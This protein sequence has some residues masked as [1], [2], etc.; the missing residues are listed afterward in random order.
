MNMNQINNLTGGKPK[1]INLKEIW[2]II[3]KRLWIVIVISILT[4]I[5]GYIYTTYFSSDPQYQTSRRIIIGADSNN[6]GTLQ[7]MI[8][9][10]SV[11]DNVISE[12]N[13]GITSEQL[14][15]QLT[16]ANVG[17]QVVSITTINSNPQLAADIV[18]T[19]A[20]VYKTEIA[21]ILNFKNV[22]LLDPAKVSNSPINGGTPTLKLI[23]SF[24]VG[25]IIGIGLTFL[26]NSLD[27]TIQDEHDIEEILNM[28]ILGKV[29]KMKKKHTKS[30]KQRQMEF[31]LGSESI[32]KK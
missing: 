26:L 1:E 17:G 13:L 27:D 14:A 2:G 20:D 23:I 10:S 18:N 11:M 32:G 29:S 5:A 25:L 6:I 31:E 16:V 12:L 9:D 7:V 8:T 3:R 22:T 24:I 15:R 4:T 30:E 28:A 19:T 21:K